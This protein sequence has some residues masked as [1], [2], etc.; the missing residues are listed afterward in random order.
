MLYA[1]RCPS[2]VLQRVKNTLTGEKTG[3]VAP[4]PNEK[5]TVVTTTHQFVHTNG[6]TNGASA[7]SSRALANYSYGV[8]G[9][10]GV[11]PETPTSSATSSPSFSAS[12]ISVSAGAAVSQQ[13]CA[14]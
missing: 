14:Y 5:V 12:V 13:T 2:L 9:G 6:A 11:P 7:Y 4:P 8:P 1:Y 3:V 10:Y